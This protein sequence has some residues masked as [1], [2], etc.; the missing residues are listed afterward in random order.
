MTFDAV[1]PIRVGSRTRIAIIVVWA[2][3]A[4]R[5]ALGQPAFQ[6]TP[7]LSMIQAYDSN[8]F[9][10]SADQQAD[11]ITRLAAGLEAQYES[12]RVSFTSQ[13]TL[14]GQRF[15]E[16]PEFSTADGHRAA[17]GLR[18]SPTAR[19]Q[20]ATDAAFTRTHMPGELNVDTG[21]TLRRALAERFLVHPSASHQLD[22]VTRAILDY[23]FTQDQLAG[24][25]RLH[26]QTAAMQ[27]ERHRS[28]RDLMTLGYAIQRFDFKGTIGGAIGTTSQAVTLAWERA[29]TQQTRLT[30]RAGPRLTDGHVAPEFAASVLTRRRSSDLSLGYARTQTTLIGL[31]GIAEAQSLTAAVTY[32][33][34]RQVELRVTPGVSRVVQNGFQSRAYHAG[35]E[36]SGRITKTLSVVTGYD[37]NLQQGNIYAARSDRAISRQVLSIG[38]VR[39]I[40]K[41]VH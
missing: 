21:L 20:F 36:L 31:V 11:Y 32:S 10:A 28:E 18:Y 38:I 29:I 15:M 8:P 39:A 27:I 16:H 2:I 6:V 35:V 34:V 33:P 9:F 7:S 40:D 19:S 12:P 17:V 37:F 25:A 13:Y 14:D 23:S 4:A 5:P 30:L 41:T 3:I 22:P 1:K 24:G 26:A